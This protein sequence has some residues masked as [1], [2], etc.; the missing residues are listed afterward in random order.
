MSNKSKVEFIQPPNLLKDRVS[1]LSPTEEHILDDNPM[2]VDLAREF[3][4]RLPGDIKQ[5][6]DAFTA[7]KAKPEDDFRITVLFRF[8]HDLK[9]LGGTFD[10]PLIS[11]I[12]N[13]L[14]RFL[15]MPIAINPA[16]LK[17]IGFYVDALGM[18]QRKAITGD[19]GDKGVRIINALHA[20]TQKVLQD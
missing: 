7:L 18:V 11:V 17:V 5:I 15:E 20:M 6:E 8:V 3:V 10:Y 1:V 16:R 12:G 4:E 13:D 19:G 9:G 14:C 2:L